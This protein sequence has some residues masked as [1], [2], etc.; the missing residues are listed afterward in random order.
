M[1]DSLEEADI[2]V[3]SH[4]V[5]SPLVVEN[6]IKLQQF[7][8]VLGHPDSNLPAVVVRHGA[9][10]LIV[11]RHLK[12]IRYKYILLLQTPNDSPSLFL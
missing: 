7:W 6:L 12:G 4:K 11:H 3:D 9:D 5:W 1:C 10:Q 2:W 8:L